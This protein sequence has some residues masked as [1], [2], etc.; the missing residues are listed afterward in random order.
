MFLAADFDE[1]LAVM[2]KESKEGWKDVLPASANGAGLPVSISSSDLASLA[3]PHERDSFR[4]ISVESTSLSGNGSAFG[5]CT[6]IRAS[7]DSVDGHVAPS[8]PVLSSY[9]PSV[10]GKDFAPTPLSTVR[11]VSV[12][13]AQPAGPA[14]PKIVINKSPPAQSTLPVHT[15]GA[16]AL[17][18]PAAHAATAGVISAAR[19]NSASTNSIGRASAALAAGL[20]AAMNSA[21]GVVGNGSAPGT[22]PLLV[23]APWKPQSPTAASPA[24]HAVGVDDRELI[25]QQPNQGLNRQGPAPSAN[26]A[27]KPALGTSPAAMTASVPGSFASAPP[28]VAVLAGGGRTAV[29]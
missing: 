19:S 11:E 12:E 5:D 29:R 3:H 21:S 23:S 26:P 24:D 20:R 17:S 7:P 16:A 22:E 13:S 25:M 6:H 28:R 1:F 8:P 15:V 4:A 10:D 14:A 2:T 18:S 27:G 9:P